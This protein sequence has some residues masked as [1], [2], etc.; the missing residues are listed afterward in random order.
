MSQFTVETAV[1]GVT[2]AQMAQLSGTLASVR[3]AVQRVEA[4]GAASEQ[5]AIQAGASEFAASWGGALLALQNSVE[6]LGETL[7]ASASA[8]EVTDAHAIP[9]GD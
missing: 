7:G 4:A 9:M 6:A 3:A 1:L 8:Y 2:G 5:G